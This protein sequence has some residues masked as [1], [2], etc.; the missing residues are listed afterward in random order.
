MIRWAYGHTESDTPSL[1]VLFLSQIVF[2]VN[3][4]FKHIW[5]KINFDLKMNEWKDFTF[6]IWL[7]ESD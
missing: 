5:K 1:L 3:F 7:T 4:S 6:N 2:I